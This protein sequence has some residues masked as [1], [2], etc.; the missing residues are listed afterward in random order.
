MQVH[1]YR[2]GG[3][4]A[5]RR[6][7]WLTKPA[8]PA[9]ES[10]VRVR[11]LVKVTVDGVVSP[12]FV[13]VWD[14]V[15]GPVL[16]FMPLDAGC[17]VD[18]DQLV[19]QLCHR[20]LDRGQWQRSSVLEPVPVELVAGDGGPWVR[21]HPVRFGT[22]VDGRVRLKAGDAHPVEQVA[23]TLGAVLPVWVR[24]TRTVATA[25]AALA[26]PGRT[27]TVADPTR[28]PG[29][30]A[31]LGTA[32]RAGFPELYPLG[33][34]VLAAEGAALLEEVVGGHAAITD[35]G[36]GWYLVAR[37]EAPRPPESLRRLLASAAVPADPG[38]RAMA[39]VAA[40][41]A[42]AESI[43]GDGSRAALH[44]YTAGQLA[45]LA[46]QA[47]MA[48]L[49]EHGPRPTAANPDA[50]RT[51]RVTATWA[52]P[53]VDTWLRTLTPVVDLPALLRLTRVDR[54]LRFARPG[55]V[56]EA[57][58]DPAGRLVLVLSDPSGADPT[59]WMCAEWPCDATVAA[60]WTGDTVLAA[61]RPVP[62]AP[63]GPFLALTPG[64]GEGDARADPFPVSPLSGGPSHLD[65]G[66]TAGGGRALFRIVVQ[67]ALAHTAA[68]VAERYSVIRGVESTAA[69]VA[70][71]SF[72]FDTLVEDPGMTL[73][74]ALMAAGDTLRLSWDAVRAAAAADFA[75]A[76]RLLAP[77]APTIYRYYAIVPDERSPLDE[78]WQV[79][80]VSA[81][82]AG[83]PREERLDDS[84]GWVRDFIMDDIDRC[85][86]DDVYRRL[87]PEDVDRATAVVRSR[88]KARG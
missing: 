80:R 23:R 29:A 58:L 7:L 43:A 40:L 18:R 17:A 13:I 55:R 26:A 30:E 31:S 46:L 78:M 50:A 69:E 27:L 14:T 68:E 59:P 61:D 44:R 41:R 28:W 62:G 12:V 57:Y 45:S 9:A 87:R 76:Q 47:Q 53:V 24:G 85:K 72:F 56:R 42:A 88:F 79:V 67:L 83:F 49:A 11:D 77:D 82:Y 36:D 81:P 19:W 34:A 6:N 52:G 5:G 3:R 54:M 15:R 65:V 33:W 75:R 66:D 38:E 74:P 8:L 73:W 20:L 37:P 51:I 39:E 60:G 84:G 35:R 21:V 10:R 48:R 71:R 86:R 2:S 25:T 63:A 22:P 16:Y 64:D 70:G 1:I 32:V 4:V